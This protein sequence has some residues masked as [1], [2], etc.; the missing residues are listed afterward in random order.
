MVHNDTLAEIS[1]ESLTK[2]SALPR[3]ISL[4]ERAHLKAFGC[5]SATLVAEAIGLP[6]LLIPSFNRLTQI[7]SAKFSNP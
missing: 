6:K 3:Y 7:R 2:R 4:V 1:W 5:C